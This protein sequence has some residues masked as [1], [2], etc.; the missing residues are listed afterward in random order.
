MTPHP[1]DGPKLKV[2]RAKR[3][4]QDLTELI[5]K[6]GA[7]HRPT[8]NTTSA[9]G[10]PRISLITPEIPLPDEI[11]LIAGDTI[12]NLRTSLDLMMCDVLRAQDK[13][14]SNIKFPF[15][16]TQDD[17]E[18]ILNK[19]NARRA[20][21]EVIE[22]IRSYKPYKGGNIGLRGLHDLDISDKH[23]L[24][25][26]ISRKGLYQ[27]TESRIQFNDK[28]FSILGDGKTTPI[29]VDPN[30]PPNTLDCL[31]ILPKDYN[32]RCVV[33][34]PSMPFAGEAVI[35]TLEK[36]TDLV[37]GII[38]AFSNLTLGRKNNT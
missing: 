28:A 27:M 4:I 1:F 17:L 26:P 12:H 34:A 19:S 36:L 22:L 10:Y 21:P 37:T 11:P 24:I 14:T 2:R 16:A 29:A 8:I 18:K 38:E 31:T 15:A 20:G 32:R 30:I 25:I 13:S 5:L 35:E 23:K 3:H 33:F 6:F 7:E 9:D